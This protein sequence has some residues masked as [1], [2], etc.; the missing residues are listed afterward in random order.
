VT[1]LVVERIGAL[2]EGRLAQVQAIYEDAFGPEL[3]VPFD[4]LT[5]LRDVDRTFVALDGPAVVGFAALRLLSSVEW[6]FL[7]YFAITAERR[8]QGLG[9]EFWRL[10][11][12]ALEQAAWPVHVVFEV[13]DPDDAAAGDTERMIRQ[14]RV[15]FWAACGARMLPVP[16]YVLPDYTDSGTA[17]PM[18][19][20]AR[21]SPPSRCVQRDHL[22]SLVLAIYADRYGLPPSHPLV[23]KALTSIVY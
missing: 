15:N 22:R 2:K 23:S 14:R 12:M 5:E 20:M 18:L 1:G 10:L 6:S 8:S 3:R 16:G 17:E 11:R 19:L 13:E 7:R 9:R 21:E 4:E